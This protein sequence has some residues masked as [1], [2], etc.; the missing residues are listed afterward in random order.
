[1]KP[2]RDRIRPAVE[3]LISVFRSSATKHE[4]NARAGVVMEQLTREPSFLTAILE[5]YLQTPRALNRKN[6]PVVAMD[7][8]LNPWFG[9]VANCWIPLPDRRTNL[10]T[11]AIHHHGDMLLTTATLFGPGYEHWMFTLPEKIEKDAERGLHTMKLIER[12]PHPHHHVS[13]VDAWTG[14]TP[15]YP[16]ALSITLALWSRRFP[17]TWLDRAKRLPLVKG[18]EDALRKV[19]DGLGLR[20]KLSLNVIEAFDYYPLGDAFKVMPVREEFELGPNADHVASVFH[21]LQET[22]N[23]HLARTVRS[24]IDRGVVAEG[25]PA[26]LQLLPELER[27]RPIAGRLSPGHYDK[28]F[29]NFTRED[30]LRALGAP[31]GRRDDGRQ[32]IASASSQEAARPGPG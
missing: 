11:K 28:P 7:V 10:S 4:A 21:I 3:E 29:A 14:H 9:L 22:G 20:K 1:M 6:Y 8:A 16:N 2:S 25:R 15:L 12:A 30:I 5:R 23:E 26:V 27:G 19:A 24:Q 32:F 31:E 13:F 17:T 18:N